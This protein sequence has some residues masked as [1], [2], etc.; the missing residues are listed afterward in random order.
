MTKTPTL[1]EAYAIGDRWKQI[2]KVFVSLITDSLN[3]V[4]KNSKASRCL[5]QVLNKF[6]E[7]RS[8][9]EDE[10]YKRVSGMN[11]RVFY[12]PRINERT[13]GNGMN[14]N[15]LNAIIDK[16]IANLPDDLM[17]R[18]TDT[19]VQRLLGNDGDVDGD[20][21]VTEVGS[22]RK[23]GK[24]LYIQREDS[25]EAILCPSYSYAGEILGRSAS[26]VSTAVKNGQTTIINNRGLVYNMWM[27]ETEEG[28]E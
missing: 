18:I 22:N 19:I 13:E 28:K 9:L 1:E 15:L 24:K 6:N 2:D 8:E 11:I 16:L 5:W 14:E 7:A 20:V 10:Y 23:E 12:G 4:P 3:T 26:Y 25:T 17:D 27:E 21:I